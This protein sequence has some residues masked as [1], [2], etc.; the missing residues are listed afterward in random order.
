MLAAIFSGL[1]FVFFNFLIDKQSIH[2]VEGTRLGNGGFLRQDLRLWHFAHGQLDLWD[3]GFVDAWAIDTQV[4]EALGT[5]VV[6]DALSYYVHASIAFNVCSNWVGILV[7]FFH[8]V[9]L[10]AILL[11]RLIRI[12]QKCSRFLK[13]ISLLYRFKFVYCFIHEIIYFIFYFAK[14]DF[15][16][17]VEEALAN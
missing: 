10:E 17:L 7:E 1:C 6:P 3:V 11:L 12:G 14:L 5:V 16:Y 8:G 9:A 15:V 13:A 2:G 4:S